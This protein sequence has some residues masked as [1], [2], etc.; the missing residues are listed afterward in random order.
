[1]IVDNEEDLR[2]LICQN[3]QWQIREGVY[4]FEFARNGLEAL[5]KLISL[6]KIPMKTI[7]CCWNICV[8]FL[9]LPLFLWFSTPH[10]LYA[11]GKIDLQKFET[12]NLKL[13]FLDKSTSYLVPHTVRSFE[14]SLAF[15]EKFWNYIP[16][17][18]TNILFNDF[19]DA[20]NG[21]SIVFPWNFIVIGVAPFDYTF[22]V[23]PSNER[24]QWLM[25]HELT[26][27]VM[28]DKASKQDCVFRS[29]MGG[30]VIA[31][32]RDPISMAYSYFA[33]PRAFSPRWYH[34][35]I[36]VFMETW[37]SG[38]I[39]RVMGGYDEMVF[40][41]MVHDS[42]FFYNV[43]GLESEGTAIDFQVG[44]N[45]YLYGTRFV[46]YLAYHY[47]LPKLKEF[48]SRTNSSK[49]YFAAQFKQVYG[50][51][52]QEEWDKWVDWE[53]QFQQS[54]LEE[55][56]K[57]PITGYRKIS[58]KP[59]G[60]VSRQYYD[61]VSKKILTALS[62]PGKLAYIAAIDVRDGAIT[63]IAPVPSPSLFFVTNLAYDDSSK[64]IFASTKNKDWRG[65]Q[66]VD[67]STGKVKELIQ[68]T[69]TGNL[70]IDPKDHSLWGIQIMSGRTG[71]VQIKPPYT[72]LQTIMTLPYGKDLS[73][74]A[75][76]P[77]GRLI[78][79]TLSDV[80]G[81]QKLVVYKIADL[82][83]G[84]SD[85]QV[86]YEFEDNPASNFV[87]SPDGKFLYGTSYYTG[88]SNVF[89][90]SLETHKAQI[91]TNAET[92]FFRPLPI[93][94][95]SMIVFNYTHDGMIAGMMK[96]DTV[97][98]V[99]PVTY[100]GQRI[101][102][103]YPEIEN[104]TLPSPL[105]IN[106]D[107]IK[108]VEERYRP[109]KELKLASAYP[110]VQGYKGFVAGGYR[111]N[112]MDPMGLN[113]LNLKLSVT[114]N[115]GLPDK[116]IPHISAEYKY[117]NWSFTGNYNYADFYDLFGPTKFSMAGYSFTAKYLKVINWFTPR[118]TDFFVKLSVYGDMETL[119]GNQNID[120]D[121]RNFY[122]G[123]INYHRSYLGKSLGA[124][125]P[126]QGYDWNVYG[127]SSLAKQAFYP[128][129]INNFDLG[130]LLPL[131]NSS[132]WFRTSLGQSFGKTGITNSYFYFG[133]F[134]NN[135]LDYRS[136]QQYRE[137]SGF[138]GMEIDAISAMNYGKFSPELD[139]KPF[140]FRKVGFKGLYSTYARLT[141]FG[142]GLFT[143]IGYNQPQI[144]QLNYYS[145]GAQLDFEIVLFSLLKS[146]LSLGYARAYSNVN[147]HD[148]FMISLKL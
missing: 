64:T 126:E 42:A 131:R 72:E 90:I 134:G 113:S 127:Y 76:S 33:T 6:S 31:D 139:L 118:K 105:K 87:F 128:Q 37:M 67:I 146:T 99:N 116:Q 97:E 63:K 86:I 62:Y 104:W 109:V 92:G 73:D 15:H 148:E 61:P 114:P 82:I 34:E 53:H 54:N 75:I 119:P 26:H 58:Q 143:N 141:L 21:G 30:K 144:R 14:N 129:L 36:A 137:M 80:T 27:Q 106:L 120:S 100:L 142:M 57:F 41:T 81:S 23:L 138:P 16:S 133:G 22:S 107:S 108:I 45:S 60:S 2:Q 115:K 39:G 84:K 69:R 43:I 123:T 77:D 88:V 98:S 110:V 59:L 79:V 83:A 12:P 7:N 52:I 117:W 25:S 101:F 132:L 8:S 44:V 147:S 135:Y 65:L 68:I 38:G 18:K 96:I 121:Y 40:R 145:T 125:E 122:V 46:S 71:L 91:L 70:V 102:K 51:P 17:D 95:D 50:I 66:S 20:G 89:R 124:I 78:S 10:S 55:I 11:Q 94:A 103:K 111:L 9:V 112:F 28:C 35:G 48:Y 136:A 1:M 24:M 93:S 3:F 5:T 32:N 19:T 4:D 85:P 130:F 47:G 49:R 13:V 56:R 74:P 29:I 140:R